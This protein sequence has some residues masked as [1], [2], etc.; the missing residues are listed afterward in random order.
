MDFGNDDLVDFL[1]SVIFE[2]YSSLSEVFPI[3][4][5]ISLA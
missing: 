5:S 3:S 1:R 4:V 2:S